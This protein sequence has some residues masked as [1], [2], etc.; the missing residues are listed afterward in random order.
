[1]TFSRTIIIAAGG[2]GGHFFP[3]EALAEELSRRGWTPALMTDARAGRRETGIFAQNQQFVLPGAGV[4]GRGPL[5]ALRGIMALL[6]GTLEARRQI[7]TLHPAAVVGFGGYPSVP[8]VLAAAFS[9]KARPSIVLHEGN[10]RAGK[11][12]AF[13]A[14]WA[15]AIGLSFPL[16]EKLSGSARTAITGMPVRPSIVALAGENYPQTNDRLR[17][18][19]WGGSLGARIFSDVVPKALASLP[20]ELRSKLDITQQ[21]RTEDQEKVRAIY[22]AAGINAHIDSFFNNVDELLRGA[23]LVIGRAGG[24]SVAEISVAGRPSVLV[25]LPFAASDEQTANASM[26]QK[27]GAAWMF[28]QSDFS[29]EA[30]SELLTDL[31]RHPEKLTVAAH[32]AAQC[33]RA[34]AAARLAD[35]VEAVLPS[36]MGTAYAGATERQHIRNT[37]EGSHRS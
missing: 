7:R 11:A 36:G 33:G 30:L 17:L 32:A 31:F 13:L 29:S 35:L 3:A 10:A 27:A 28:K 20:Q 4:V 1:M 16:A 23:H 22:L 37:E 6:K 8:P 21:V 18:L 9:G 26:L 25:P 24:S 15:S 14:R 2:T 34:D 5:R 19:I 12:N